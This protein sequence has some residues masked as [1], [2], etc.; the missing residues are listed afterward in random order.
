MIQVDQIRQKVSGLLEKKQKSLLGQFMT[1]SSIAHFMASLFPVSKI[2]RCR[3]LDPGAGIGSLSSAFIDR[4]VKGG[5]DFH[6]VDVDAFE[7]DPIMHPYL[8]EILSD[9]VRG[10]NASYN[11]YPDDFVEKAA[12][13]LTRDFF[14]KDIPQYTH[15]ILNPPYKKI[16]S[17]SS[18]RRA[19]RCAGIETVNLYSAFVALSIGMLKNGG[20]LVAI[21]PRSFCNGPYYRSFREYLFSHAAL[22]HIHIFNARNKAFRDE[23][24]LQENIIVHFERGGRQ[25]DVTVSSST[26]GSF[27]DFTSQT[28]S[29]DCIIHPGDSDLFIHIDSTSNN[30]ACI[31]L[32]RIDSTLVELGIDVS[33]GPVVD[34]RMREYLR[35]TPNPETVPLLYPG[36][37]NDQAIEWPKVGF[38]KPNALIRNEET[39]KW[40]FPMGYYTVVRRFSSK[41]ESRR[42]VASVVDPESFPCVDALAFENHLNVFHHNRRGLSREVAYGLSVYL[43]TKFP[44]VYFRTFNGHTQVN[45]TDLRRL[46]YPDR[47]VLIALGKW[48]RSHKK[49]VQ[50]SMD[51][52]LQSLIA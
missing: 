28:Q 47:D 50:T 34:F 30:E 32:P 17:D 26:D 27:T 1:P 36:H 11:I 48:A 46:K 25:G 39:E 10:H 51:D 43:N 20:H 9:A 16:N 15:A 21:I 6:R 31:N 38:K 3:L 13:S 37:F 49:L 40:L 18:H 22:H 2:D 29:F 52:Q 7:V 35:D 41:E 24:V 8:N 23:E 5:F 19:L 4:W 33:T 44:E 45:A 12:Q 14:G 42:I